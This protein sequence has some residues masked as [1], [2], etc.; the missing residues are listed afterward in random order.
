MYLLDM[1]TG[2]VIRMVD[3]N[4]QDLVIGF[5]GPNVIVVSQSGVLSAISAR[6]GLAVWRWHAPCTVVAT[7]ANT[8][9]VVDN[10]VVGLGMDC[11][12]AA[13]SYTSAVVAL[14]AATGIVAW[15]RTVPGG[16]GGPGQVL[17]VSQG[18]LEFSSPT[19]VVVVSSDGQ[20]LLSAPIRRTSY[21][22]LAG[23][24]SRL[25]VVYQRPD[26][27]YSVNLLSAQSGRI[28][29]KAVAAE[30][31]TSISAFLQGK[32]AEVIGALPSP[33][34]PAALLQVNFADNS[35]SVSTLPLPGSDVASALYANGP[36]YFLAGHRL[37][38][39]GDAG[40]ELLSLTPPSG[41][42]SSAGR[43]LEL[44]G[45]A[46]RWPNVC[47]L[48]PKP[49]LVALLGRH[50]TAIGQST[51]AAAG[52][53]GIHTCQVVASPPR[54]LTLYVQIE[55]DSTSSALAAALFRA[56]YI[57]GC[58]VPGPWIQSCY[59]G[60]GG[61]S[62]DDFHFLAHR[63]IVHVYDTSSQPISVSF[64]R[65]LAHHLSA[66]DATKGS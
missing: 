22:A 51:Q 9:P 37:L 56:S 30:N 42:G 27:Q 25:L 6:T 17:N 35:R 20:V 32:I 10:D 16:L 55:W 54:Q 38:S 65:V 13:G 33:L 19:R 18:F 34:L 59:Q 11:R 39:S 36:S 28:V 15:R 2:K 5:A 23:D 24:G 1:T 46:A 62:P 8:K 60:S 48:L 44:Q 40:T 52:L 41:L 50:Y 12:T 21:P 45:S 7:Y 3:L 43:S 66:S 14:H 49:E 61:T 47:A 63:L 64:S 29:K 53:P 31:F 57:A 26:S 58:R 4:A